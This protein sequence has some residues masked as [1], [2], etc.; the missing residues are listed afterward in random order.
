MKKLF[1]LFVFLFVTIFLSHAQTQRM[2]MYEGFSNASC[3]PC[4][5]ANPGLTALVLSNPTKVVGI[6]YQT[7]WP[8]TDPM[9]AQTQTWVQPRVNYY[10]ITGVPGTR[11]DGEAISLTQTNIN[12]HYN[13]P[14]PFFLEVNHTFNA[15]EDSV[16]V[17]VKIE[18]AQDYTG[19]QLVLHTAMI[20]NHISFASAPGSNGEK[21]FYK[22]M[23]AMY[24]NATGTSLPG[25]WVLGQD[26]TINFAIKI[27]SYIYNF[28]EI[29]FVTFI[30][31]NGNKAVLQAAK[32][33]KDLYASILSHNIPQAPGCYDDFAFELTVVNQ[34]KTPIT[35]FDIEY[36]IVGQTLMTYNWTGAGLAYGETV[37]ITLPSITLPGGNISVIAEIK[38]PNGGINESLDGTI[39]QGQILPVSGYTAVPL[40]EAF[41]STTF[42]PTNWAI[43]SDDNIKWERST[44]AGFGITPGGSARIAFYSSPNGALD[45]LYMKGIDLTSISNPMLTFSLAHARYSASYTDR[46]IIELS[47]NCGDTWTSIYNKAGDNLKTVSTFVTSS[48]TP[49]AT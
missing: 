28:D 24:P 34:G 43:V 35:S 1:T 49:T 15:A 6:K 22:V 30:Q 18:A 46:L 4:A 42:P 7:N 47:T 45:H 39:V 20:E 10:N 8:G 16:F 40:A 32:T 33:L 23:R 27:P 11:V 13:N 9:N 41:T 2:V 12:N 3:A 14:S 36:G 5:A 26:T 19:S 48:F 44:A 38:N 31:S 37:N 17:E 21:N 29:A 25:T